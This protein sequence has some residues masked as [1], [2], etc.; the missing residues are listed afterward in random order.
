MPF[1]TA[2]KSLF[3]VSAAD[4]SAFQLKHTHGCYAA[5]ALWAIKYGLSNMSHVALWEIILAHNI[6]GIQ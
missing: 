4:T 1:S 6:Q 5:Y 2:L 3:V